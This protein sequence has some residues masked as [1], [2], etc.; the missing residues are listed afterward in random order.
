MIAY[1]GCDLNTL[2]RY[3]ISSYMDSLTDIAS[4][5][6]IKFDKMLEYPKKKLTFCNMYEYFD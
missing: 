5:L 6:D 1:S 2:K 3:T 4:G